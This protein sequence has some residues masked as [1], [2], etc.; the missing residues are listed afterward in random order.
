MVSAQAFDQYRI[1]LIPRYFVFIPMEIVAQRRFHLLEMIG[2]RKSRYPL[3]KTLFVTN[4]S[5]VALL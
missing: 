4:P 5:P 2:V 1:G 3:V